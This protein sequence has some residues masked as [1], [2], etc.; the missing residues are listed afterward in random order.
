[1]WIKNAQ[2]LV[3]DFTFQ[4]KDVLVKGN[5]ISEI[6][7]REN[8]S[9]SNMQDDSQVIDL[10]GLKLIPGLI[11]VHIHGCGG[12]GASRGG[13]EALEIMSSYLATRGV[14]S[15]LATSMAGPVEMVFELL[16]K[17]RIQAN[18]V[19]GSRI[20]G[21][22]LEG[23][24]LNER[25]KGAHDPEYILKPDKGLFNEWVAAGA[26]MVRMITI[27]PEL[28]DADKVM[29]LAI[30]NNICVSG[31]HTASDYD[32]MCRA[33]DLGVTHA[34]HLFNAMPQLDRRKPGA[35]AA[36]LQKDTVACEIIGDFLHVHP[37]M[38]ELAWRMKKGRLLLISDSME[39][40]GMP[41]GE[42]DFY[43]IKKIVEN[44]LCYTEKGVISGGTSTMIDC[45]KNLVSL[46]V[47]LEE[48]VRAATIIPA[49]E[50]GI[51][52]TTGS[53]AKG[54]F[55][56]L[57]A[58]DDNLNPCYCWVGGKLAYKK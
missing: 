3:D 10:T 47:S 46:G 6:V 53:I 8:V 29:E 13:E 44:G 5:T 52:S 12:A 21:V 49:Q 22:H 7:D 19:S 32:E 20:A 39:A 57:V 30:E 45:V 11:D 15:F 23:P 40:A 55:A 31:G 43:G 14:T 50:A 33:I 41:D 35:A 27:A 2:V 38:V 48:A 24:F 9:S 25:F 34:T 42:Y 17:V 16:Q 54:K 37:V 1:M 36:L 58:V 51:G 18:S 56:D 26:G 28:P 4:D